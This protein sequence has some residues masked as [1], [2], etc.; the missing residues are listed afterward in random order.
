[1]IKCVHCDS[2]FLIKISGFINGSFYSHL[3]P[4]LCLL[5][6]IDFDSNHP[7]I[8]LRATW[9]GLSGASVQGLK[10]TRS[11]C[12]SCLPARWRT[13]PWWICCGGRCVSL[14]RTLESFWRR[15]TSES[16]FFSGSVVLLR[17]CLTNCFNWWCVVSPGLSATFTVKWSNLEPYNTENK[18][19]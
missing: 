12:P 15:M 3:S 7:N 18:T 16:L 14:S 17:C 1:M 19:S 10:V 5:L 11:L 2:W 6:M 4:K 13:K 8:R 9:E